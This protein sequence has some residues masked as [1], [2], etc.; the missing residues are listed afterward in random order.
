MTITAVKLLDSTEYKVM[1][2][3]NGLGTTAQ[4]DL[5]PADGEFPAVLQGN[6]FFWRLSSATVQSDNPFSQFPGCDRLLAVLHG[7]GLSLN[8]KK[9]LPNEVYHFSGDELIQG[10]L[11]GGPVA[12][13]GLIF[14]RKKVQAEMSFYSVAAGNELGLLLRKETHYL[15]CTEGAFQL[16]WNEE[17]FK[18]EAGNCLRLDQTSPTQITIESLQNLK[19]YLIQI[20]CR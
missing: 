15:F 5:C 11:L 14:C 8:D 1:P 19:I 7:T 12:D 17:N 10:N 13:L 18:I 16:S 2:W 3:K 4:I 6:D 20:S 9:L